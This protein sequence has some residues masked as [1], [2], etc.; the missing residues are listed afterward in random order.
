MAE[1]A[2]A[3]VGVRGRS[4][5][6]SRLVALV[7]LAGTGGV[8]AVAVYLRPDARGYGTHQQLGAGPCGMLVTT[9]LP[10]PT[11]GMTTAFAYTVRG[12]WLSALRA[13]PGGFVLCLGTVAAALVALVSLVRGRWPAWDPGRISNAWLIGI[14]LTVLIGGW[15]FKL[16]YGLATG[17][18]PV[19]RVRL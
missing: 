12:Q 1:S 19:E 11:C 6:R 18:L 2:E 17:A 13:Q 7:V 10:C 9:G 4:A 16:V 8:L 15:A 5:W 3:G 14:L